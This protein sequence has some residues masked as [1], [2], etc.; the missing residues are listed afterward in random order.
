M[1][2]D[3]STI[4]VISAD[5]AR[6][7]IGVGAKLLWAIDGASP[8]VVPPKVPDI[9]DAEDK[10]CS[11]K[12]LTR[13][14]APRLDVNVLM[15]RFESGENGNAVETASLWAASGYEEGARERRWLL[16]WSLLCDV[17]D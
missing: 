1:R 12:V 16:E 6:R 15:P 9:Y 14:S 8:T 17:R 13:S 4:S 11:S 7:E 10:E 3:L 2:A 5:L